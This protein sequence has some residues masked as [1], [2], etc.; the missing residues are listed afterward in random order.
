MLVTAKPIL[1][2]ADTNANFLTSAYTNIIPNYNMALQ[3]I[4]LNLRRRSARKHAGTMTYFSFVFL[5][6]L[7]LFGTAP[8]SLLAHGAGAAASEG[9]LG[10]LVVIVTAAVLL[11]SLFLVLA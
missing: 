9:G 1:Y 8:T 11:F 2:R 4:E 5:V 10:Q 3:M 6:Y 7:G